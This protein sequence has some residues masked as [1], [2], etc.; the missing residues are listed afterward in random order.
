MCPPFSF[1]VS[2]CATDKVISWRGASYTSQGSEIDTSF[3]GEYRDYVLSQGS[4]PLQAFQV[5]V[6]LYTIFLTLWHESVS[7]LAL[8]HLSFAHIRGFCSS[9]FLRRKSRDRGG[10]ILMLPLM[11]ISSDRVKQ[12]TSIFLGNLV[13][14]T[15]NV[16]PGGGR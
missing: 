15:L 7:F 8:S 13:S 2:P 9:H 16:R 5:P 1:G 10:Q 4:Q 11:K 3:L 14:L 6:T 12:G